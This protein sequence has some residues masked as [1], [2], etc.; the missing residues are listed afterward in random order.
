MVVDGEVNAT[1]P[2]PRVLGKVVAAVIPGALWLFVAYLQVGLVTTRV[3]SGEQTPWPL[4][5]LIA[6]MI[7]L[8][9]PIGLAVIAYWIGHRRSV[10]AGLIVHLVGMAMALAF[11]ML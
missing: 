1:N 10:A 4:G 7:L 11:W 6:G 3:L 2:A 5:N 9:L 8:C